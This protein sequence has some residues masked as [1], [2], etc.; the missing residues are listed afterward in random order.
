VIVTLHAILALAPACTSL[1][2]GD[3]TASVPADSTPVDSAPTDIETVPGVED[4]VLTGLC[5]VVLDCP[6]DIPDEPKLDCDLAI[7]DDADHTWYEGRAGVER[8]GRSSLAAPKSQ[9][10]VELRNA[11]GTE[12]PTNLFGFGAESDW[13]FHGN[14]FDRLLVRNTLAFELFQSFGGPERY[15]PQTAFCDL[16]LDGAPRGVY[17]VLERIKRDDDRIDLVEDDGSGSSFVVKLDDSGWLFDNAMS[18]GGWRLIYPKPEE[19]GA[20]SQAGIVSF[21]AAWESAVMGDSPA[22]PDNGI[23][24]YVD[25]DSAVDFVILEEFFKNN[26]AYYLSV[27]AWRDD[28]GRVHFVPWDL[29]LSLGQPSYNDNENPESWILHRPAFIS[30]M[31]ALPQFR[32]RLQERWTELRQGPLATEAVLGRIDGYQATMGAAIAENFEIWPIGSIDFWGYLYVVDSYA[33]EDA[34]VRSW[35]EARL[36]WMDEVVGEY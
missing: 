1:V 25:L 24:A 11:D 34:R 17:S 35:I 32:P 14:Y 12:N 23:L 3:D 22:D 2:T 29:D 20:E 36:E 13:V 9:Y 7:T 10:S 18:N 19:I 26:D 15:A 30:V 27:H 8:R 4:P 31:A 21:L 28:G 33:E 6:S 16:V 5:H